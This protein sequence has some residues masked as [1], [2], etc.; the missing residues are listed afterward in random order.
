MF[1]ISGQY[2]NLTSVDC[3]SEQLVSVTLPFNVWDFYRLKFKIFQEVITS[4]GSQKSR[5]L[6]FLSEDVSFLVFRS[7][8]SL[9]LSQTTH[10]VLIE[11]ELVVSKLQ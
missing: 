6:R 3:L 5:V 7:E 1:R 8:R 10:I 9:F 11:R 2:I 4:L